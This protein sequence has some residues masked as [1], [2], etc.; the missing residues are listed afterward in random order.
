IYVPLFVLTGIVLSRWASQNYKKMIV[1]AGLITIVS[2]VGIAC[3]IWT[4]GTGWHTPDI[5]RLRR[6]AAR[7]RQPDHAVCG[8]T[9]RNAQVWR[10]SLQILAPEVTHC[11]A[12]KQVKL[13]PDAQGLPIETPYT[14]FDQK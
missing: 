3:A 2:A 9:G 11:P 12:T 1:T 7:D 6:I 4:R 5:T 8:F 10:E 13:I 14:D